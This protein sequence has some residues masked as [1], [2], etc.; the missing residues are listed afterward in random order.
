MQLFLLGGVLLPLLVSFNDITLRTVL[1]DEIDPL[2]LMVISFSLLIVLY[3]TGY[4]FL[5]KWVVKKP[6]IDHIKLLELG[7]L[8]ILFSDLVIYAS[9]FQAGNTLSNFTWLG[10]YLILIALFYLQGKRSI[11][12]LAL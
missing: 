12:Q 7:T 2:A 11:K 6:G 8:A 1:Q 5:W 3:G 10:F 4:H 9:L